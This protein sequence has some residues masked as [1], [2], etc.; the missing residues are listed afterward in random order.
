MGN[1]LAA[2]A[3][4]PTQ[5]IAVTVGTAS[6][7]TALP[8]ALAAAFAAGAAPQC[9]LYNA[10]TVPVF[11][12]FGNLPGVTATVPVPNGAIGDTP[13]APGATLALTLNVS[14]QANFATTPALYVAAVTASG[15][16]TLYITP[17]TGI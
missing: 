16:A 7:A 9:Q 6:A 15:S 12:N 3:P 1:P 13:I 11:V 8:A 10:G 14:A 17:G 5:T 4:T 2:F